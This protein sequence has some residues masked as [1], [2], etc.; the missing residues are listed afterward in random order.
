VALPNADGRLLA[1]AYVQVALPLPAGSGLRVPTNALLIRG[2]G[3][4]V[5]VVD[6]QG[7]VKLRKISVGRNY[8]PDFEVLDGL[9]DGER[10]V[11][12]PPDGLASGQTVVV[13]P[14]APPAAAASSASPASGAAKERA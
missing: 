12:N 8:G 5:A 1:G 13:V 9:A 7:L 14:N 2:E 11:L 3:T 4:L 10:L 6:A